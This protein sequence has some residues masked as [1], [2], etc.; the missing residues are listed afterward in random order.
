M[1]QGTGA[2]V[3][4]LISTAGLESD[5]AEI[6]NNGCDLNKGDSFFFCQQ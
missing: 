6:I 2:L 1:P 4:P 5:R 3:G